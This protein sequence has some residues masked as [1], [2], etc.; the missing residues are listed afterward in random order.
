[1]AGSNYEG[2]PVPHNQRITIAGVRYRYNDNCVCSG[3]GKVWMLV[4]ERAFARFDKGLVRGLQ[5]EKAK[6]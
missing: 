5:K 4:M 3:C 2:D 1:M 6:V